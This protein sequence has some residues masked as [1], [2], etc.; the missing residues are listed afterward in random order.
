[1]AGG[2]DDEGFLERLDED[3]LPASVNDA[4]TPFSPDPAEGESSATRP[5]TR[6]ID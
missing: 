5:T 6:L 1:L 2:V 3:H 4:A